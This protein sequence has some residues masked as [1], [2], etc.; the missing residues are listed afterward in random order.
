M[1]W[2]F[3]FGSPSGETCIYSRPTNQE[4]FL[5]LSIVPER[6]P[7]I[8]VSFF[9]VTHLLAPVELR[10]SYNLL[11]QAARWAQLLNVLALLQI[12]LYLLGLFVR[13]RFEIIVKAIN[14]CRVNPA[15][16]PV[17]NRLLVAAGDNYR[18]SV[19]V[20]VNLAALY[21]LEH[22][23]PP[24]LPTFFKLFLTISAAL[25]ASHQF[26][27][28]L[29]YLVTATTAVSSGYG[30]M[31]DAMSCYRSFALKFFQFVGLIDDFCA[32]AAPPSTRL[33]SMTQT[34]GL[35]CQLSAP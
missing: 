33:N 32:H 24:M 3:G 27:A 8:S 21:Q 4:F 31:V 11:N 25:A 34:Q 2:L 28:T 23:S 26:P 1:H 13:E 14:A 15:L 29:W 12:C 18:P 16:A 20:G 6:R 35:A 5:A 17:A 19:A 30:R 10:R 9:S 22:A 7:V